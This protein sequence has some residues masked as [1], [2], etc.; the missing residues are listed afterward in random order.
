M[1]QGAIPGRV[2]MFR[3]TTVSPMSDTIVEISRKFS[4]MYDTFT[5]MFSDTLMFSFGSYFDIFREETHLREQ[6]SI[7]LVVGINHPIILPTCIR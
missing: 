3:S 1:T 6:N 5:R 2:C 4:F 7:C